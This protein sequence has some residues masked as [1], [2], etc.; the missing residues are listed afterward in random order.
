MRDKRKECIAT[1]IEFICCG[2][3]TMLFL[4]A[5]LLSFIFRDLVMAFPLSALCIISGY[6]SVRSIC[7]YFNLTECED[8][9]DES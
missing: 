7:R 2:F 5:A 9:K 4:V 6:C 3:I 1:C 8:E